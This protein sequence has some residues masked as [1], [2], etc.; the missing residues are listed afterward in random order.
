LNLQTG[1]QQDAQEFNRLLLQHL[2][3]VMNPTITEQFRGALAYDTE[4]SKCKSKSTRAAHFYELEIVLKDSIETG[5]KS[6]T[7]PEYL[8]GANQVRFSKKTPHILI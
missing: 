8:V 7:A 5:L 3:S 4:C 6:L 2:E 1:V